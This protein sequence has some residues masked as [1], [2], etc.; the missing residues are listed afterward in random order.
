MFFLQ[1]KYMNQNAINT[2]IVALHGLQ[3]TKNNKQ[4]SQQLYNT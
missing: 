4:V 1:T 2:C 3:H